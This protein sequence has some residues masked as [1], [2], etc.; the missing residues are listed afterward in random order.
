MMVVRVI[1]GAHLLKQQPAA[2]RHPPGGTRKLTGYGRFPP[3]AESLPYSIPLQMY[4]GNL[5]RQQRQARVR[6]EGA[7]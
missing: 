2:G 7:G 5:R 3:K 4:P 1:Y 6:G